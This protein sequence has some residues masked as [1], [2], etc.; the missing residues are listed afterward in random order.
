MIN[1]RQ[2]STVLA[3]QL[4]FNPRSYYRISKVTVDYMIYFGWPS[5]F[6]LYQDDEYGLPA[7][8]PSAYNH[9][10]FPKKSA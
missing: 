5:F 6:V 10:C 1:T 4:R 3:G 7:K 2:S 9:V 8:G